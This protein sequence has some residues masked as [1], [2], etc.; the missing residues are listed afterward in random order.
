[1]TD[2]SH[3]AD[4]KVPTPADRRPVALGIG[5]A[6]GAIVLSSYAYVARVPAGQTTTYLAPAGNM[7]LKWLIG[8]CVVAAVL[9][10]IGRRAVAGRS[11][12]GL[13]SA[14]ATVTAMIAAYA[15]LGA[16]PNAN[17]LLISGPGTRP[18]IAIAQ[19]AWVVLTCAA[20]AV[21]AGAATTS[22][23]SASRKTRVAAAALAVTGVALAAIVGLALTSFSR[24][25]VSSATTAQPIPIPAIPTTVGTNVAYTL[26][27]ATSV[28]LPAGPGFVA[29]TDNTVVGYD[30]STGTPRWRFPLTDLPARCEY[31]SI[32]STGVAADSVVVV[33]CNRPPNDAAPDSHK[34][35]DAFLVGLDA[36][37]GQQLW[38]N[39]EDWHLQGRLNADNQIL[40][41][42]NPHQVAALDPR[43]G[44]PLW[45]RERPRDGSCDGHWDTVG[46]RVLYLYE[47]GTQLHLYTA[48]S[49][50]V[51]DLT[52]QPGYP[53]E[54]N[55]QGFAAIDG[56]TV[57]LIVSGT[58]RRAALI[59]IDTKNPDT[60]HVSITN[61]TARL[62]ADRSGL[63]PGPVLE[64]EHDPN[65]HTLTLLSTADRRLIHVTGL[66][67][68][69]DFDDHR[70][71]RVG[72][73]FVTNTGYRGNFTE[74]LATVSSKGGSPVVQ[75]NPCGQPGGVISVP[76][77]V[78]ALCAHYPDKDH[79]D[80]VGLR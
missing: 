59:A 30:G 27:L 73:N 66:D 75:P 12:T 49:D 5:L 23:P 44:K 16:T 32:R 15:L 21:L 62:F 25:G 69:Y 2:E 47:C 29:T 78:L 80:V 56:D 74:K 50:V 24:I 1:M 22:S 26:N 53:A 43:T 28:I 3:D 10:V 18:V 33:Q 61:T 45:T 72:D 31:Q 57:A 68:Y 40:A 58:G 55:N 6:V 48:D 4:H 79:F 37:T 76:G 51:I 11:A 60:Q 67:M 17:T 7:L 9:F 41:A 46:S 52:T 38:L 35:T 71:A 77:A 42:L 13:A 70:W 14:L 8:V 19:A 64:V 54:P 36:T 39:D 34:T 20:V 63:I 65:A